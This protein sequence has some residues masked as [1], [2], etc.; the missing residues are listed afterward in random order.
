VIKLR[1]TYSSVYWL[2][3][4]YYMVVAFEFQDQLLAQR[5][6]SYLEVLKC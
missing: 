3:W 2:I 5:D 6:L 1:E 4:K